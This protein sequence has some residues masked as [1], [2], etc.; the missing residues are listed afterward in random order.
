VT[1]PAI[2]QLKRLTHPVEAASLLNSVLETVVQESGLGEVPWAVRDVSVLR[3]HP[4]SR[5]TLRYVVENRAGLASIIFAKVYARNR[6]DIAGLLPALHSRGLG[7]GQPVQAVPLL[8]YSPALRLLLLKEAPGET[9]GA[10]LRR[11]SAGVGERT[12]GWL[13]SFQALA[14]LPPAY[15]MQDP[16]STAYRWT[17]SL[18][19]NAPMLGRSAHRLLN[20]LARRP[21][22]WPPAQPR[23]VHGDFRAAHV[24]LAEKTV[25]VIDW[26]S[27]R[28]G[29]GTED[30][31]RFT[32]SLHHLATRYASGAET[33]RRE[34]E[35]FAHSYCASVPSARQNFP[36]Y[37]AYACLRRATRLSSRSG[38]HR[39]RRAE[40]L[41]AAGEQALGYR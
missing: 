20:A 11:G 32:A 4:G 27:W 26:D 10:A 30:A 1:D 17:Q 37:E 8:A 2:P 40:T 7:W 3:A 19:A 38:S 12:A 35:S 16:L 28:V 33:V 23:L 14:P 15:Y 18:A 41:L 13:A 5:W 36:F 24:Y 6:D 21:P 25:T 22:E 39:L 29:D 9:A 31:G 34:T